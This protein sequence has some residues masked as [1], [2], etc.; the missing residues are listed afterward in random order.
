M[1]DSALTP[2]QEIIRA[3]KAREVL[4][5]ELFSEA[6]S[7]VREGIRVARLNSAVTAVDLREK[8][9]AQEQALEAILKHLKTHMES[10][11]LAEEE[12]RRKTLLEQAKDFFN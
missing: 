3:G 12:L 2:E 4:E 6:V 9:W 5:N 7:A 1:A 10:G 11:Q 8:L